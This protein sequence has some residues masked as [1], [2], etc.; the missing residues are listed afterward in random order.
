MYDRLGA[1]PLGRRAAKLSSGA[2]RWCAALNR[3]RRRREE[4]RGKRGE[5]SLSSRA[6]P[7]L[8]LDISHFARRRYRRAALALNFSL[9]ARPK[10][11]NRTEEDA[12]GA[13]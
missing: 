13:S 8:T 5:D 1:G 3:K 4:K 10:E 11:A 2:D 9:R 12:H 6:E 7:T